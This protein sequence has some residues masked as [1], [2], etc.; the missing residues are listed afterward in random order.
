M[1]D[2]WKRIRKEI[3]LRDGYKC[4]YTNCDKKKRL[5]VHH[6][7]PRKFLEFFKAYIEMIDSKINL[8]TLCSKHHTHMENEFRCVGFTNFLIILMRQN[9]LL[10]NKLE[11]EGD[12]GGSH[13]TLNV[14]MRDVPESNPNSSLGK[15]SGVKHHS[16]SRHLNHMEICV[17]HR[18][19]T[20]TN[21]ERGLVSG[22]DHMV[23]H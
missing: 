22:A 20:V 3:L 1:K 21:P 2:E 17:G 4:R 6:I 11:K 5:G 8:I 16:S 18:Q 14:P 12:C 9:L 7:L 19:F 10:E 15:T 13:E 23:I